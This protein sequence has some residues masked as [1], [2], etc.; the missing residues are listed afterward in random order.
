MTN[1]RRNVCRNTKILS[2]SQTN[3]KK[4][5]QSAQTANSL[6]QENENLKRK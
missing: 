4:T 1:S 5:R 6:V 2:N 3:R